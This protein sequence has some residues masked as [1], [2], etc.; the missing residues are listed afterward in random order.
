MYDPIDV[1]NDAL[2]LIGDDG[3]TSFSDD[4]PGGLDARRIYTNEIAFALGIYPFSF[5]RRIFNLALLTDVTPDTGHAYAYAL[6]PERIGPPLRFTDDA[7]DPH[8]IFNAVAL[9]GST[10]TSDASPLWAECKILP[11]PALW[12]GTFRQAVVVALS[13][14]FLFART[15]DRN[16]EVTRLEQA[17][18]A[19]SQGYRGGLIAAAI[20][21]D[22]RATPPR[23]A[24]IDSNPLIAA[25][26]S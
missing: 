4:V 1:A 24:P 20:A 7:R 8:R 23:R 2:A 25:W 11:E 17:Y 18:G 6:P 21:E 12:S 3:V 10:V 9:V 13:G 14:R 26:R 19:S 15:G 22:A 16:G 5:A